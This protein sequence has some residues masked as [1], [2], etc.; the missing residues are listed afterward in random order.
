MLFIKKIIYS[1]LYTN[2]P[3]DVIAKDQILEDMS[4]SMLHGKIVNTFEFRK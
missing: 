2:I 1:H 3:R 4:H